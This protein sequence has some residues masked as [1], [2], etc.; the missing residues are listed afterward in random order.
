MNV[1]LYTC[2]LLLYNI[3]VLSCTRGPLTTTNVILYVFFMFRNMP[4]GEG[5]YRT[6]DRYKIENDTIV[7]L[8]EIRLYAV[9]IQF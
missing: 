1:N 8:Y 3:I 9:K 7:Y 2:S 5:I 6:A 4:L